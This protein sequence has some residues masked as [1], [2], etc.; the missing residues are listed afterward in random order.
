VPHCALDKAPPEHGRWMLAMHEER[1]NSSRSATILRLVQECFHYGV[2]SSGDGVRSF[3]HR[4]HYCNSAVA[5]KEQTSHRHET[6]LPSHKLTLQCIPAQHM[7]REER[8]AMPQG[9]CD[10]TTSHALL[11]VAYSDPR[12]LEV[13][14]AKMAHLEW[15]SVAS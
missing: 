8:T 1:A 2:V 5:H 7:S 9:L 10:T 11:I 13:M 4:S 14:I 12:L 6:Q 15:V 3:E